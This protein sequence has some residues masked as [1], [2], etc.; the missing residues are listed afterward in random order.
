METIRTAPAV[1][2]AP[3]SDRGQPL[4]LPGSICGLHTDRSG[5]HTIQETFRKQ[6]IKIM[7]C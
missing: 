3:G 1:S 5:H 4:H 7:K 6:K 2:P